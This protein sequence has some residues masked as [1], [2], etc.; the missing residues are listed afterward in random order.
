M[1]KAGRQIHTDGCVVNEYEM[2]EL[3][4]DKGDKRRISKAL[5]NAE[6]RVE[7]ARKKGG[8]RWQKPGGAGSGVSAAVLLVVQFRQRWG[9]RAVRQ[10]PCKAMLCLP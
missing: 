10:I 8:S 3:A 4:D 1:P 7:A 9:S 6:K 2:D 5:K